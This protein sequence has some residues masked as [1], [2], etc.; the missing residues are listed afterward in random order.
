MQRLGWKTLKG[1]GRRGR[2]IA[3]LLEKAAERDPLLRVQQHWPSFHLLTLDFR[4]V[5][6][7]LWWFG[8]LRQVPPKHRQVAP[9]WM[10]ELVPLPWPRRVE[11]AAIAA[12]AKLRGVHPKTFER[13][14]RAW[15]KERLQQFAARY[16]A[17]SIG[18][19]EWLLEESGLDQCQRDDAR[20]LFALRVGAR[21]TYFK[22]RDG[23]CHP[24]VA[25]DSTAEGRVVEPRGLTTEQR[26]ELARS[27]CTLVEH[28]A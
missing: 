4:M 24:F 6:Y 28:T 26:L 20:R 18:E 11:S 14:L 2:Q 22:C 27:G 1:Q 3:A 8:Q 23:W 16:L 5:S 13:H 10:M 9:A 17:A 15:R 12:V 21:Y 19:R 25:P 7:V